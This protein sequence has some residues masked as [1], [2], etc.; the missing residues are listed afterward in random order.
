MHPRLK[1][2]L[3]RAW[4]DLKTL[5]L[6][7]T[8]AHA[9]TIGPVGD[10]VAG[11]LRKFDGTRGLE[12]LR[13]E[14]RE[15][16]VSAERLDELLARLAAQ[17]LLDDAT[18][19]TGDP[20]VERLRAGVGAGERLAPEAAA[21]SLVEEEPGGGLRKL[22]ARGRMRVQVRGAG[23]VGAQAAA[24]LSAAG[25][26]RVDVVDGGFVE[27]AD[28]TPGGVSAG[29]VGER[30]ADAARRL[31]RQ[32][33]PGLPARPR[34]RAEGPSPC[35]LSP[36]YDLV[37][38]TPRDGLAAYVPDPAEA[39]GFAHAGIPHLYAGVVEAT[40]FV[41]PLVRPG[42]SACAGCMERWRVEEDGDWPR[43]LVQWRSGRA[44]AAPAGEVTLAAAVA[45][46]AAGHAL[47]HL[48]GGRPASVGR[49]WEAELACLAWRSTRLGPHPGCPCGARTSRTDPPGTP[50]CHGDRYR[51]KR[52]NAA[53]DNGRGALRVTGRGGRPTAREGT[54]VR[55]P[56]RQSGIRIKGG[57]HV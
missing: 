9:R 4:R 16:G 38:L 2:T 56:G 14:A 18:A 31:A 32:C 27:P 50:G 13:K 47:A 28:V 17:G 12:L 52:S 48:D 55:S 57:A 5:Q 19:G 24:L 22:A 3:R 7:V 54:A 26:G 35:G 23:R 45:G 37:V 33:A 46:L 29:S 25:V 44:A 20:D 8:P 36:A 30:R 21:L 15:C 41:G 10:G 49:R 39:E 40:G 43:L 34:P 51:L 11:L 6:G 53:G 1:P 42:E